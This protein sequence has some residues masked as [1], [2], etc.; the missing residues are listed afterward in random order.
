MAFEKICINGLEILRVPELQK[1]GVD[2]FFTTRRYINSNDFNLGYKWANSKEEVDKNFLILFKNLEIDYRNIYYAKQV[3]KND[4]IIVEKGFNFFEYTQENEADG[5]ITQKSGITLITFH[6]DCIPIYI[7]DK[8]KKIIALIHSGWR[9]SLQHI[10]KRAIDILIS[11]F[12][13]NI[14]NLIVVIG[15]GICKEH[16]EVGEEVY[17]AFLQEFGSDICIYHEERYYLDLKKAIEKDLLGNGLKK[18]QI[19]VSDMCTYEKEDLFFSYRRD[20]KSPE[21]LG[22][23]VALMRMVG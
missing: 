22:S 21:K 14:S 7:Y 12:K 3:H 5:L 2:A 19:I 8:E 18:E 15:P 9:G 4:I 16:F 20:F 11:Q 10:S 1:Y 23:M 6:A 17:D 13:C